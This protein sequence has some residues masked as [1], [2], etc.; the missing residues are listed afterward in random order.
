MG[1]FREAKFGTKIMLMVL[2]SCI[3]L[4]LAISAI[5]VREF[6]L[7]DRSFAAT[8]RT[9]LSADSDATARNE[10]ESAV[11]VLQ[12]LQDRVGK[13]ELSLADAKTLGADIIRNMR[14]GKDGY[15]WVDTTDGTNV[16]FLGKD[17]E[18][19]SRWNLQDARGNY[20]IRDIIKNGMQP[21][22]GY[23]NYW[24]PRPGDPRPLPKR[25]YSK[26]FAPFGWVIGTGNYV[27]DIDALVAT[28]AA[29]SRHS[30]V[31]GG[32]LVV[33]VTV[34]VLVFIACGSI[35]LTRRLLRDVGTEPA[36]LAEIAGRVA[37]GDLTVRLDDARAGVYGAMRAM[38][39]NLREIMD[40]VSRSSLAVS[41]AAVQLHANAACTS[42]NAEEVVAQAATV[43]TAS[44]EMAATSTDIAANCHAAAGSSD[45][46]C[47]AAQ[48]GAEIVRHTIDGMNRIAGKVR[49][50]AGA[51]EQLGNRSEQIGEIVAT[52]EDIADQTNLLALNAAIEAARAGEQGRG[53][54]VVA[55]EVRALAERTTKATRE[56]DQMIRSI[57]TETGLAVRAMEE[58]VA[59]V[60]T[61]TGEAAR[62]GDA[63]TEILAQVS[64]V[65]M[66]INQIAT[67]AEE[68]TA[69][70]REI[71]MNIQQ[72]SDVV[73]QSA[74]SSREV[75]LAANQLSRLSEDMLQLVAKFSL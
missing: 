69:T 44:E 28:A 29:Q 73:Q 9:S 20:I 49:D 55:D 16:V 41:S 22:G 13:G 66:Q 30:M 51:V 37:N 18:G 68:Q 65:T 61:G 7:I 24:F 46:A 54:A 75:S 52:I 36:H 14:Y 35:L 71:S 62:S 39:E 23:T 25:S 34:V 2:A 45:Q 72:I 10:V 53:F 42:D 26:E 57:Q 60:E 19:R 43:S 64:G 1:I 11:S 47:S 6:F 3:A 32:C 8:Y 31:S 5:T 21:D 33:A 56:I 40:Q 70:T 12:R 67:A 59:E 48:Q 38:V 4:A 50:S 27:D 58:G 74:H 63:L 15:L 17:T